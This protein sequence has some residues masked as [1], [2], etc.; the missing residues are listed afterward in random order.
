M[1]SAVG[2]VHQYLVSRHYDEPFTFPSENF[3]H[4]FS[5]MKYTLDTQLGKM[6]MTPMAMS[7]PSSRYN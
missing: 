6:S 1:R 7:S 5:Y 4:F 2:E 3:S